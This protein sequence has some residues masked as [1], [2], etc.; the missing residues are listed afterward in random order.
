MLRRV[1]LM[2]VRLQNPVKVQAIEAN[3]QQRKVKQ[4][5]FGEQAA[6][7]VEPWFFAQ[8][9]VSPHQPP[10]KRQVSQTT[11]KAAQSHIKPHFALQKFLHRLISV[12]I[13]PLLLR[14][15]P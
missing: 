4:E 10:A 6:K 3:R 2:K 1:K 7:L 9:F 11:Q 8:R 15:L 5:E 13:Q 12:R 14:R